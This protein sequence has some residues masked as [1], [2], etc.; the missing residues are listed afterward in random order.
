MP[1]KI[2]KKIKH[3]LR[4]GRKYVQIIRYTTKDLCLSYIKN[5]QNP[6]VFFKPGREE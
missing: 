3:R 2:V 4:T 6:T 5:C 1:Q